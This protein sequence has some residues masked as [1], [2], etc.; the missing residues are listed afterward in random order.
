MLVKLNNHEKLSP[1]EEVRLFHY[2]R[3]VF[4]NPEWEYSQYEQGVLENLPVSAWKGL[5]R[6]NDYM[7]LFWKRARIMFQDTSPNFIKYI[8]ENII[9]G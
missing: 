9:S 7:P 3:T 5:F 6:W 8:E 1:I 4:P 2:F